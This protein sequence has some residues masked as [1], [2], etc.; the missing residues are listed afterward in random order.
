MRSRRCSSCK[1]RIRAFKRSSRE[2]SPM[3]FA[4]SSG[5]TMLPPATT[6]A[7]PVPLPFMT[8]SAEDPR[9]VNAAVGRINLELSQV[10]QR[11]LKAFL[12][13][14]FLRQEGDRANGADRCLGVLPARKFRSRR[15]INTPHQ[16][17]AEPSWL[18]ASGR[19][20]RGVTLAPCRGGP[21]IFN[22]SLPRAEGNQRG[23]RFR[24]VASV[25]NQWPL[26]GNLAYH[27]SCCE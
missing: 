10:W 12:S 8:H 3:S 7:V 18:N 24:L 9:H 13:G 20:S 6:W 14:L 4:G 22:H 17:R 16:G 26:M 2:I 19:P 5:S 27:L 25:P 1:R 11:N 23:L 15:R 21:G